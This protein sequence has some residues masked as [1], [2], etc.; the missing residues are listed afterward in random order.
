MARVPYL[1]KTDLAPS[2]QALLDRNL[3]LYRALANSPAAARA[4]AAP[5]LYVRH[6]SALDPRL[7]ELALVQIGYVTGVEYEYAHH[8]EIGINAGLTPVDI[9]AIALDTAGEPS[10]FNRLECAVLAATRELVAGPDL[11]DSTY[12]IL[13]EALDPERIVDLIIAISVYCGVVRLLGAL[14]I[15]LEEGYEHYLE[16]FPLP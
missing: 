16:D 1:T 4:F 8:I 12:S 13:S 3:N 10:H 9:R 11:S 14:Q 7:R 6:D 5:A 2:D 15:E